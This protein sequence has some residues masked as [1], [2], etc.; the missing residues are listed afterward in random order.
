MGVLEMVAA[1]ALGL[2]AEGLEGGSDSADSGSEAGVEAT[3][4]D[5]EAVG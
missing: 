1:V 3:G 5:S 2:A 4:R